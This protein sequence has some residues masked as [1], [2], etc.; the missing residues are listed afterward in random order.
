MFRFMMG[1]LAVCV[2]LAGLLGMAIVALF[3]TG[4]LMKYLALM[5]VALLLPVTSMLKTLILAPPTQTP[6]PLAPARPVVAECLP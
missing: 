3:L 5:G 4:Y 6:I 1:E 2:F